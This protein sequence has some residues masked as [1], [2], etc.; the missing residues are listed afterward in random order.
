MSGRY[1]KGFLDFVPRSYR[2]PRLWLEAIDCA[3]KQF[4]DKTTHI[5][6][7]KNESTFFVD[8]IAPAQGVVPNVGQRVSQK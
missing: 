5:V 6:G 7:R 1:R 4:V 8:Q 2:E 3:S